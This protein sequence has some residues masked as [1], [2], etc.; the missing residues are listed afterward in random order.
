MSTTA[1]IM[2]LINPLSFSANP[3]STTTIV[4]II[5]NSDSFYVTITNSA[6]KFYGQ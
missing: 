2:V 5:T 6:G 3:I 4:I 1:I